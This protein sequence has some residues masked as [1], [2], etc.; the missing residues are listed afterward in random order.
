MVLRHLRIVRY[1]SDISRILKLTDAPKA[2]ND[3]ML[4]ATEICGNK[5]TGVANDVLVD[6]QR[7]YS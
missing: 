1:L 6:I 2:V 5:K 3:K 4:N 7:I